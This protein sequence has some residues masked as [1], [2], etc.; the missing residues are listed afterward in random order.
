ME[1][2]NTYV[3][4]WSAKLRAS[5]GQGKK[6]FTRKEAERLAQELNHDYP[7]F[8]HEAVAIVP[9]SESQEQLSVDHSEIIRDTEFKPVT[10]ETQA[11]SVPFNAAA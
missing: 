7:N 6:L 3:I 10:R 9:A 4:S 2:D 11:S 8:I 5:S 1:S